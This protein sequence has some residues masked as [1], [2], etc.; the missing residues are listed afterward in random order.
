MIILELK[1]IFINRLIIVICSLVVCVTDDGWLDLSPEQLDDMLRKASGQRPE[2]PAAFDS[3]L[4]AEAMSKFVDKTSSFE[5]AEFPRFVE[6]YIFKY[7]AISTV[8][9]V[10]PSLLDG[11]VRVVHLGLFVCLSGHVTQKKLFRLTWF[12]TQRIGIRNWT[13]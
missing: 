9:V 8:S 3:S 2:H 11:S 13:Q 1:E 4:M 5:G 12:Y 6:K 7:Q 10:L